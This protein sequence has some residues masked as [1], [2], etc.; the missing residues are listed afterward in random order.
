[1]LLK[2]SFIEMKNKVD[3]ILKNKKKVFENKFNIKNDMDKI[4]R[5]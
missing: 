2:F 5:H 3:V 4:K 1:M